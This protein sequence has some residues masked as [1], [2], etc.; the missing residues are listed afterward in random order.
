MPSRPDVPYSP[1]QSVVPDVQQPNDAIRT[2]ATPQDFGSQVAAA[3]EQLGQ[4]GQK[5][6]DEAT[7]VALEQ[8]GMVNQSLAQNAE[9]D[10]VTKLSAITDGYKSLE[11]LDAVNAKPQ[12]TAQIAALKQQTLAN[13]PT[14]GAQRAFAQLA[15]R[16]EANAL[17]DAGS[18]YTSQIKAGLVN[19]SH[20]MTANAINQAGSFSVASDDSR[21]NYSLQTANV[22]LNDMMKT[23][24][25]GSVMTVDPK[26]GAASFDTS[27]P[28]G[29]QAQQVYTDQHDAL[30]GK[31]WT[32]RIHALA[33]DPQSGNPANAFAVFQQNRSQIPPEAQNEI[34]AYL[35][36][37][38][39]AI[40]ANNTARDALATLD[41]GYQRSIGQGGASGINDA[42]HQQE[43][44]GTSIQ[45][46]VGG[47]MPGT[48]QQYAKPGE[49]FSNPADRAAVNNRVLGDLSQRFNGDPARIAVGYFS[50][51]GNVAPA[52][53]P[54][55]WIHDNKD[56]N[57]TS[58]SGYVSSVLGRMG[59]S[60]ASSGSAPAP[61]AAPSAAPV[62]SPPLVPGAPPGLQ[63]IQTKADYYRTHYL[64]TVATTTAQAQA[65]HP[66]DPYAVQQVVA[67]VT[68]Q[69]DATI[70]Q[71]DMNYKAD[72]DMIWQAANGDLAKGTKPMTVDQLTAT[73]PDVKA[74]WGRMQYQQPLV[75]HEVATR[76]L[77]EN[78]Q[79]NGG[80]TKTYGAGFI[81]VFNRIHAADGDPNKISDPTQLY[82]MVG[83]PGGLT[84]SGLEKARGEINSKGTPDGEAES[85]MRNTFFKNA[86]AEL[87]GA[88]DGLGLKDPKGE[89]IYLR[90]MANAYPAIDK[91]KAE[92]KSA[93]QIYNPDSPD[94]VGKSIPAFKRTLAQRTADMLSSNN[95]ASPPAAAAPQP[96][97]L[98]RL[99]SPDKPP[100][101]STPESIRAAWQSGKL[102][103]QD[104]VK[105][106]VGV[107]AAPPGAAPPPAALPLAQQDAG[108]PRNVARNGF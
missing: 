50:G 96:G 88:D 75:A 98:G 47:L 29:Q 61:G 45:G 95:D 16:H 73:N 64:D 102:S 60:G 63:P 27:T 65:A 85:N 93:A 82:G 107:G 13:I 52:G 90:F 108:P 31:A 22:G 48:F 44:T 34:A 99:F 42:I 36:P 41:A 49:S 43:G 92:G 32:S 94:Y 79:T 76:L 2:E 14:G 15:Q 71:Q 55:P 104:A 69:M 87:T 59:I 7:S 17:M 40:G 33:D 56:G 97:F 6:G 30:I 100:D 86:H 5:I 62:N 89:N 26:T 18:Y 24:G 83:Q 23:Q 38:M 84:M 67:R 51:P 8:Q 54:T 4:T 37:K 25:Y 3:G 28:Q 81:S 74:A 20:A 9:T 106:L 68:Q 105:A 101:L 46:A 70:R 58:T 53:S 78:A 10:Y 19:S 35:N 77:S 91:A 72:S 12:I 39:K 103:R 66:D 57:G 80:D 11:G 1:V 21:F